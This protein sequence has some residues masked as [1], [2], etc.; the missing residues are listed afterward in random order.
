M[1]TISKSIDVPAARAEVAAAWTRFIDSVLVGRLRLACDELTCVDPAG[2]ELVDFEDLGDGRTRVSVTVPVGDDE[3]AGTS[4]LLSHKISHDFVLFWDFIDSGAY[5]R[6]HPSYAEDSSAVR[7]DLRH[8]RLT[9]YDGRS[10]VEQ[11]SV[12]RQG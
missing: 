7:D 2:A 12:H 10:E 3:P 9:P 8:G 6:D 11:L 5:R 4:D 1:T